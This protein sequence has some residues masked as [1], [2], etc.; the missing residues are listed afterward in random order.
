MGARWYN[1]GMKTPK[2]ERLYSVTAAA[3]TCG[4]R[5]TTIRSAIERGDLV[6]HRTGCGVPL[7]QIEDVVAWAATSRP[8]GRPPRKQPTRGRENDQLLLRLRNA[9]LAPLLAA[10][11]GR[12]KRDPGQAPRKT[13][14]L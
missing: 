10:C 2:T 1:P 5:R 4:L 6:A 11:G 13:I 7:V 14:D 3:Q 12:R 9:R 8:R